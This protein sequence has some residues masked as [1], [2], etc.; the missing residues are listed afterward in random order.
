MNPNVKE[1]KL[2]REGEKKERRR[3][4]KRGLGDRGRE[5]FF[6]FFVCDGK[7]DVEY[8]AFDGFVHTAHWHKHGAFIYT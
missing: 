2:Q 4:G 1:G 5:Y 3:G 6:F 8:H 7:F